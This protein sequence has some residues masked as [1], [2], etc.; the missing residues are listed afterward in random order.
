M[1]SRKPR[2]YGTFGNMTKIRLSEDA[3]TD[4]IRVRKFLGDVDNSDAKRAGQALTRHIGRLVQ[5]PELVPATKDDVRILSIP[6]GKRGYS[7]AYIYEPESD[8]VII[9]GIKHQREEFF[10]FELGP[11]SV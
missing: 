3:Q 7:A 4:L 2:P 11:D 1:T 6:F 8:L 5:H 10:P 9:F